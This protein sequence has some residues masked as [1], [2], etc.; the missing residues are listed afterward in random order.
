MRHINNAREKLMGIMQTII[1]CSSLPSIN[2]CK[3]PRR[4]RQVLV[5][6]FSANTGMLADLLWQRAKKERRKRKKSLGG[7]L[8]KKQKIIIG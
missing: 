7:G 1:N 4:A 5:T 3:A 6:H 2:S 8:E